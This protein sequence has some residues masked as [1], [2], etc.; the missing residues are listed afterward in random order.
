MYDWGNSAYATV[1]ISA[2]LP[3]YFSKVAASDLQ[4]AQ[5]TIYWSYTITVALLLAAMLAPVMGAIADNT[6]KKKLFLAINAGVGIV[7]TSLL[8]YAESGK[9]LYVCIIFIISNIGFA[10]ADIFYNSL[11]KFVAKPSDVDRVSS[12]GYALGYLG[13]G[14]LLGLCIIYFRTLDDQG[15]AARL[16]FL[17][18]A[19]WWAVFTLPLLFYVN[20]PL[21]VNENRGKNLFVSGFNQIRKTFRDIRRYRELFIF[22]IAFWIYNDGIGTII[23]LATI[24]GSELGLDSMTLIGALLVT[25]FVGI[26]FTILFGRLAGTFGT[27]NSIYLGL[28]VY[29][30]VSIA[31]FFMETALHFWILA[32]VVGTVQGGTQALSRSFFSQMV[33]EDKASEFFGFYGMSTKFAGIFGPLTFA[34]IS[35]VTGSSRLGIIS[36]VIFFVSGIIVLSFVK[37]SQN[38][39]S[40]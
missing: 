35:Q 24:Y 6:N 15:L 1:I 36:L 21:V 23:K 28:T 4:P 19:V 40:L 5:A 11:L 18:V 9:W 10:L 33:P 29:T 8:Y 16:S 13:G 34:L 12:L 3:V 2:I 30:L 31:A 25:Q 38:V 32:V 22:L 39:D 14:L 17:S 26:P 27:K 37:D 20:E 7:F